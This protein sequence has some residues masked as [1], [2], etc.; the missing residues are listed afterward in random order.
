MNKKTK[1]NLLDK[2][3]AEQA[4]YTRWLLE[5]T[6]EQILEHSLEY[7]MREDILIAM[8]SLKLTI[9]QTKNLLASPT[10]LKYI[11]ELYRDWGDSHLDETRECIKY[12]AN[13][14]PKAR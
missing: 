14:L 2:M 7:T 12:L 5:Q 6:P 11:Y 9:K 3:I 4:E 13:S 8:Y 10:P 1:Q